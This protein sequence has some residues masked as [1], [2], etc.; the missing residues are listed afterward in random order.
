MI[1]SNNKMKGYIANFVKQLQAG[2]QIGSELELEILNSTIRN[3][4]IT[5]V[6]GSGIGGSIVHDLLFNELSVPCVVNKG[7]SLPEFVSEKS[8]VIAVSYSGNT[9]ET[10]SALQQAIEKNAQIVC[11]ASGGAMEAICKENQLN[12]VKIPNGQPPRTALLYS[13]TQ[14][15]WIVYSFGLIGKQPLLDLESS[16]DFLLAES[17]AIKQL[18][19]ELAHEMDKKLPVLYG[20]RILHASLVRL[21][22][23]LNENSK[24]LGWVNVLP[25]M[26][27]NE[28]VGWSKH[29]PELFVLFF[30]LPDDMPR[31]NERLHFV[32]DLIKSLGNQVNIIDVKGQNLVEQ[33]LYTILLGDWISYELAVMNNIDAIQI[34]AIDQLKSKL[35]SVDE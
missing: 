6:G 24:T 13:L 18:A 11:I 20:H 15:F 31:M 4:V 19:H 32:Y 30:R 23:Q 7:Y 28:L 9:E 22:Q 14:L 35:A 1:E 33:T 21:R 16:V 3:V 10:L 34:E 5:G 26:N 2:L 12:L 29:Y 25:E 27:H 8:L 17:D